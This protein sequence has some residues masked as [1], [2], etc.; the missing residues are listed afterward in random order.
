MQRLWFA[1]ASWVVL[2]SVLVALLAAAA[3]G[4]D[5]KPAAAVDTEALSAL[6]QAAVENASSDAVSAEDI[7]AMVDTAVMKA[8]EAGGEALTAD[9]VAAIVAT[10]LAGQAADAPA[11]SKGTVKLRSGAWDSMAL[12]VMIAE[13]ILTQE[14]DYDV[15]TYTM[16]STA[17]WT[18]LANNDIDIALEIWTSQRAAE[19]KKY[20][21]EDGTV[22]F[23]CLTQMPTCGEGN[24]EGLGAMGD[25]GW[26]VP[27]YVVEG[28]AARGIEAT[29][30]DLKNWEQ[31]NQY[32]DVFATAQ[33]A[34]KGRVVGAEVQWGRIPQRI[35]AFDLEY[36]HQAGGSEA[37]MLAEVN[38][39]FVKGEAVLVYAYEPSF[40]IRKFDLVK[41][42]FEPPYFEGCYDGDVN[43]PDTGY[44][45]DYKHQ[46]LQI[47][48]WVG[49][50]DK[51]PEVHQF[52]A[53]FDINN[54]D[55]S[56]M[57]Y[58]FDEGASYDESTQRWMDRNQAK[59]QSWIP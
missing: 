59:W 52:F 40:M 57:L 44:P 53:N 29:A 47:G 2:V 37:A 43:D 32:K 51:L 12:T 8:T 58:D 16:G 13:K 11:T 45:C 26:Y 27:R 49:L 6:V 14:M 46:A 54:A 55:L 21:V 10:A 25:E 39:A 48:G 19:I 3:C 50:K 28:D 36:E 23:L 9:E 34:P 31:L 17:Q 41:I 38:G 22:E 30:P 56:Q 42:P 5:D 33:T 18:A 4:G 24:D 7:A 15:E 1:K 20:I 35:K